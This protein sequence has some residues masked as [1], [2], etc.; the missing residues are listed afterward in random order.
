MENLKLDAGRK[1]RLLA[2]K[3]VGDPKVRLALAEQRVEMVLTLLGLTGCQDTIVGNATTRGV[4]CVSMEMK[5]GRTGI[6]DVPWSSTHSL[7]PISPT[8]AAASGGA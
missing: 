1:K 3:N 5:Y 8:T 2:Y 6:L 7:N 4:R